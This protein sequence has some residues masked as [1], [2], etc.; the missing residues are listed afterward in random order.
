MGR[1]GSLRN[2]ACA[3]VL[4]ALVCSAETTAASAAT[5]AADGDVMVL[6]LTMTLSPTPPIRPGSGL[7]STSHALSGACGVLQPV[8][9]LPPVTVNNA[10]V[11]VPPDGSPLP[12]NCTG[13]SSGGGFSALN[14]LVGIGSGSGSVTEPNGDVISLT[15]YTLVVV[16]P[17]VELLAVPP[18]GGMS[19]G[20]GTG[21]GLGVGVVGPPSN[22]CAGNDSF[23]V[24]MALAGVT[25]Q[26]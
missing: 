24:T 19:E 10:F 16:G 3:A 2:L 8:S 4:S 26:T 17:V 23:S 20:G 1:A 6:G 11:T 25:V 7:F 21:G 14:C 9:L 22:L 18:V 5:P 13:F 12:G 15:G